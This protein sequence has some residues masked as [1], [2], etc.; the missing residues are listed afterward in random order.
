MR[1]LLKGSSKDSPNFIPVSQY[2]YGQH[3]SS[4]STLPVYYSRSSGLDLLLQAIL[5]NYFLFLLAKPHKLM[6]RSLFLSP[7]TSIPIPKAPQSFRA[8]WTPPTGYVAVSEP[9]R[10]LVAAAGCRGPSESPCEPIC[11][12]LRP[13][14]SHPG[15]IAFSQDPQLTSITTTPNLHP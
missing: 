1:K 4:N 9:P 10:E 13:G 5:A 2:D 11:Y 15:K 6:H 12:H 8:W 7:P 14:R 3:S